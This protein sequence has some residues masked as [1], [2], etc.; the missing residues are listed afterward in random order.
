M[1]DTPTVKSIYECIIDFQSQMPIIKK[2]EN[3]PFYKSK[4]A[5]L[6]SVQTN[7]QDALAKSG[8]G[9]IQE[10]YFGEDNGEPTDRTRLKTTLFTKSGE[11]L[12]SFYPVN[13]TGT[14]QVIGSAITYAK[15]YS[16][17]ALLGIIVD[18]DDDDGNGAQSQSNQP[19]QKP[20][21]NKKELDHCFDLFKQNKFDEARKYIADFRLSKENSEL[22]KQQSEIYKNQTNE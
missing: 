11:K 13:A 15:R 14:A 2:T 21:A 17:V 1:S 19:N 3:N 20:W 12:E 5:D 10:V 4:Y 9:Y 6:A 7:I 22:L 16:L 8:L 18:G